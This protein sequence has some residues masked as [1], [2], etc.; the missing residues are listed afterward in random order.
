M[1]QICYIM[2]KDAKV[3]QYICRKHDYGYENY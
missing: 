2:P 1:L 3:S